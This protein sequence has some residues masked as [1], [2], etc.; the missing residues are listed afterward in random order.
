MKQV[1]LRTIRDK[2]SALKR[3]GLWVWRYGA[4]Y[5]DTEGRKITVNEL[6][7]TGSG[8]TSEPRSKKSRRV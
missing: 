2:I 6:R 4:A 5:Y 1:A 7:R 3:K 8:R